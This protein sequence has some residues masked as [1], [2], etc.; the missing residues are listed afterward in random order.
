MKKWLSLLCGVMVA[1]FICC[2]NVSAQGQIK[3]VRNYAKPGE[4][5][6]HTGL[7]KE[8]IGGAKYALLPGDP[9]RVEALA[10]A[11]GPAKYVGNHRDFTSWLTSVNGQPVLVMSTG[12][13]GPCITFAVEELARLGVTNFIRVGTC[14]SLQED[15]NIGDVVIN[16]AAVR[17]DGASKAYAPIEYP[18]VADLDITLALRQAAQELKVP[19]K[20]GITVSTDSFWPGQERYDGFRNYVPRSLQGSLQEWQA[21]NCTNF[22][23]EAATLFVVSNAFGL[24]SG[25][26]CGVMAKRTNSEALAS[27]EAYL[28]GQERFQRVTKRALEILLAQK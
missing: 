16:K 22:E 13:G 1:V 9:G 18:A 27:R 26:I 23:M 11:M 17:E 15:L 12:M 14:G 21:L 3:V 20:V 6:Y 8:Q 25:C 19:F 7:T 10:K 5:M 4:V 2:G 24:R 28:L